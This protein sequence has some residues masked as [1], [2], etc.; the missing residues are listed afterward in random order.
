MC[1]WWRL[2]YLAHKTQVLLVTRYI[3]ATKQ[4]PDIAV[5]DLPLPNLLMTSSSFVT[6]FQVTATFLCNYLLDPSLRGCS[7]WP[8]IS[9]SFVWCDSS[10][11]HSTYQGEIWTTADYSYHQLLSFSIF[12]SRTKIVPVYRGFLRVPLFQ[13]LFTSR[14]LTLN[15][16]FTPPL[17]SS[18]QDG[19]S[20]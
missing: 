16:L 6:L 1:G 8:S 20:S 3:Q 15:T 7:E 19:C 9:E 2:N 18:P 11:R 4:V 5:I 14:R 13:S 17:P 12:C 10:Y